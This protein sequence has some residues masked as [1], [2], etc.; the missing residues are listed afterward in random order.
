MIEGIVELFLSTVIGYII[1]FRMGVGWE[2]EKIKREILELTTVN[3]GE[4]EG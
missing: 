3:F 4:K 1:G 2:K